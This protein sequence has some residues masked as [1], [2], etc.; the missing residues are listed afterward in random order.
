MA[1]ARMT[2]TGL[3]ALINS[4]EQMANIP[5]QVKDEI[6]LAQAEVVAEAQ[7]EEAKKLNKDYDAKNKNARATSVTNT[8]RGQ[9][10]NYGTGQ[11]A[12]SI[13]I[14]NPKWTE[15]KRMVEIYF[16]GSRRRGNTTVSN[17]EIAFLNEYGTRTI[18]AR[19]WIRAAIARVKKQTTE[20]GAAVYNKWLESL[21][22]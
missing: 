9:T 17:Q 7:R 5:D 22:L 11:T 16:A 19:G 18:N 3:D 21:G 13:R 8:L 1:K 14:R 4:F 12:R 2:V 10:E 15:A 20:A 6:L